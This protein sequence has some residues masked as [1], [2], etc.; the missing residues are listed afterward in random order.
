M[1]NAELRAQHTCVLASSS[2][3]CKG[4]R[5]GVPYP[6]LSIAEIREALRQGHEEAEAAWPALCYVP[7]HFR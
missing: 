3:N 1:T 4:C 5:D 6:A 7:G 2:M